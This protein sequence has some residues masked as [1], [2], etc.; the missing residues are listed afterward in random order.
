MGVLFDIA[1]DEV[2]DEADV[3]AVDD[4]L[5]FLRDRGGVRRRH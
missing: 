4:F 1:V 2:S 3:V 5:N